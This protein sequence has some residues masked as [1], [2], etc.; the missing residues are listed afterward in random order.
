LSSF[1]QVAPAYQCVTIARCAP[2]MR[3]RTSPCRG[4]NETLSPHFPPRRLYLYSPRA[5]FKTA[6]F[7]AR[8]SAG[9]V[10]Y[11]TRRVRT[12]RRG[13]ECDKTLRHILPPLETAAYAHFTAKTSLPAAIGSV[14]HHKPGWLFLNINRL[15]S[16]SSYLSYWVALAPA[17]I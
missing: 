8:H 14:P 6:E 17:R 1:S 5:A 12:P 13:C 7:S 4:C 2:I 15:P 11:R 10:A 16:L 9:A 3:I